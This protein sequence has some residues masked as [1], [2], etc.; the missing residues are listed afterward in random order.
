MEKKAF[1]G[2]KRFTTEQILTGIRSDN[3]E[4]LDWIQDTYIPII[5]QY[6]SDLKWKLDDAKDV[7]SCTIGKIKHQIQ[8]KRIASNKS[9]K[10]VFK[11][12]MNKAWLDTIS[13]YTAEAL[14]EGNSEVITKFIEATKGIV[15]SLI[16][17]R[18]SNYTVEEV[19]SEAFWRVMKNIKAKKYTENGTF[20]SYFLAIVTNILREGGKRKSR[21]VDYEDYHKNN[22]P[23]D[24][25]DYE[26]YQNHEDDLNR[27]EELLSQ[28][29]ERC[30]EIFKLFYWQKMRIQKIADMLNISLDNAKK[31]LSRCRQKLRDNF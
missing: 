6:L 24:D 4:I 22:D 13:N 28:A 23:A 17:K 20:K 16:Q 11:G 10:E 12:A 15:A 18:G 29:N 25:D 9:F 26:F 5:Q 21:Q 14:M 3:S 27:L 19:Y 30:I 7:F 1:I 31:R 8:F 2:V